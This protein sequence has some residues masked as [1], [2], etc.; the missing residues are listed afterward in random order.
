MG[1]GKKTWKE[2]LKGSRSIAFFPSPLL[3]LLITASLSQLGLI[4]SGSPV[5]I[6]E[7]PD[8]YIPLL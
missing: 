6:K 1:V 5:Y 7:N 3:P 2:P 8:I 4:R